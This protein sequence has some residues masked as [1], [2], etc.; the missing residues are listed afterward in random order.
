MSPQK[1]WPPG[2][3][4]RLTFLSEVDHQIAILQVY[5]LNYFWAHRPKQSLPR[6]VGQE[7]QNGPTFLKKVDHQ[8]ATLGASVVERS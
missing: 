4:K 3:P 6:S 5:G 7:A 8:I 2:Y 1:R